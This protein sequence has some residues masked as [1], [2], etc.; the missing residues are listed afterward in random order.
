[1]RQQTTTQQWIPERPD[2]RVARLPD[3]ERSVLRQPRTINQRTTDYTD[4]RIARCSDA[5]R[6]HI[7][8]FID[9]KRRRPLKPKSVYGY[10]E[11]LGHLDDFLQG[12]PIPQASADE[13]SAFI[14]WMRDENYGESTLF[15]YV[16]KIR[17]YLKHTLDVDKLPK[18]IKNALDVKQP[19]DPFVGRLI[20]NNEF[21]AMLDAANDLGSRLGTTHRA[22]ESQAILW[23]LLDVGHRSQ[24]F[25]SL[26]WGH[27]RF[28]DLDGVVFSLSPLAEGLKRGPRSTYGSLCARPLRAWGECHRQRGN[29][30]ASIVTAFRDR[31]GLKP[32]SYQSLLL[33]IKM[34]GDRSGVNEGRE[35]AISPH[36]FRHTAATRDGENGWSEFQLCDKYG[37]VYGSRMPRRY[38]HLS[39]KKQRERVRRDA[40]VDDLGY[41]QQVEA[42]ND[43]AALAQLLQKIMHQSNASAP[44]RPA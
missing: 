24:E 41:R 35:K 2:N 8:R 23:T 44:R 3:P 37:W 12:K 9:L 16:F 22:E 36:D 20:E 34:L 32:L 7:E 11:A 29:L 1:M 5:N 30:A 42:G 39:L 10:A 17:A 33:H 40:G 15:G 13:L 31:T 14:D 26:R 27:T 38:L 19:E 4:N 6:P 18:A 43:A 21:A 25:L 28:E